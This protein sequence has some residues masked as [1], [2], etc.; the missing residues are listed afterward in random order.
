MDFTV[1]TEEV[2]KYLY[3]ELNSHILLKETIYKK[4]KTICKKKNYVTNKNNI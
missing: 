1:S 2:D 4:H 3:F